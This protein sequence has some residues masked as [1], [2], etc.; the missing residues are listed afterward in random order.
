MVSEVTLLSDGYITPLIAP[1]CE[2]KALSEEAA[3]AQGGSRLQLCHR[4]DR[5]GLCPGASSHRGSGTS[6]VW[7]G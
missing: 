7:V 6:C 2:N 4:R 1:R 3:T 5:R